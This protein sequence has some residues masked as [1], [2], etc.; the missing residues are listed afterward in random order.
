MVVKDF[1]GHARHEEDA[2]Q[3]IGWQCW[4]GEAI[5][6]IYIQAR[7]DEGGY[8]GHHQNRAKMFH[9]YQSPDAV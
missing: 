3:Y 4:Y 8:P 2:A 1:S 7:R 6:K 9:A 5:R